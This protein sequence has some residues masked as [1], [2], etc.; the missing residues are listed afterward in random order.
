MTSAWQIQQV[1]K[2]VRQGAVIAYPTEA[3]WG[4]GC[5]PFNATAVTRL[6]ALKERPM[7]KGLI[8]VA[9]DIEQLAWLLEGLS[10]SA[11]AQLK[12]SWPGPNTWLVPHHDRVPEWISGEH[13]TVAVRVSAH[14]LVVQ[15]CAATGPLVS[16]SAN[17]SGLLPAKSRLR[18]EQYFHGQLDAVLSGELGQHSKPSTIRDLRSGKVLRSA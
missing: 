7:H 18:I 10:D 5:D 3:V 1:A 13:D 6:L 9:A 16:T 17:P 8:L 12:Q 15:L 11:L 14:P 2:K 4:L